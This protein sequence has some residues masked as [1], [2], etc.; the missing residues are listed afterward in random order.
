[1]QGTTRKTSVMKKNIEKIFLK[2]KE[3]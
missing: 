3:P 2:R 1:M